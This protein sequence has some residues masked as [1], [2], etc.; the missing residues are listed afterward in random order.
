MKK[1]VLILVAIQFLTSC[2][3]DNDPRHD[4]PKNMNIVFQLDATDV[5]RN[6]QIKSSIIGK[7]IEII[8]KSNGSTVLP[9][10]KEY[11]H[12]KIPF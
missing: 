7:D 5:D 4:Y 3:K 10:K 9:Y 2:S 11:I 8:N 6:I 1:I 12:Q